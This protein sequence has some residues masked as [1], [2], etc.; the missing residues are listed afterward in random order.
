MP[1]TMVGYYADPDQSS[2]FFHSLTYFTVSSMK[3]VVASFIFGNGKRRDC[4]TFTY[5][6]TGESVPAGKHLTKAI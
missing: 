3:G 6:N 5:T 2:F 4:C 1:C